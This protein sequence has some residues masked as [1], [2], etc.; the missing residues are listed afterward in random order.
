MKKVINITTKKSKYFC[1]LCGNEV[2]K[3]KFDYHE[4]V[5]CKRD[6]CSQCRGYFTYGVAYEYI[7][8]SLCKPCDEISK[9]FK[10]KQEKMW[11]RHREEEDELKK[12]CHK[13]CM[14]AIK[15]LGKTIKCPKNN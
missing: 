14:T 13:A 7:R 4:C 15:T 1:D 5:E 10:E 12:R 3:D 2:K 11:D 9:P 6:I 8:G